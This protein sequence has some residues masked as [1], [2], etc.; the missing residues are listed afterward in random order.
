MANITIFRPTESAGGT[1][2]PA[3]GTFPASANTLYAR[4]TIATRSAAGRAVVP[5]AADVSGLPAMGII[6]YTLDNRTGAEAGGLDDSADVE[7]E[8]G[9]FGLDIAAGSATLVPGDICYVFDNHSVTSVI[10]S[11]RGIAGKVSEVRRNTAGVLQA[12]VTMSPIIAGT[13][14]V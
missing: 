12:Y 1:P 13:P 3:F 4:G 11:T 14:D 2:F 10:G 9:T 5:G 7:V 6:K 8:Y